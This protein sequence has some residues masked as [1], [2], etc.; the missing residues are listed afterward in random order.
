MRLK[1]G[2]IW[3]DDNGAP[4][5][6][7]GGC[8]ICHDGIWYWYGENKGADN[9]PGKKQT[10]FV[11]V[12][13][14]SSRNLLN[15]HF[16]GNV[17]CADQTDPQSPLH[18]TKV[19]ERPKVIF[20]AK[21]NNFVLWMHLDNESYSF[22]RAGVAVSDSPTGPF[23]LLAV[24]H[25]N[26]TDCRDMTVFLDIDGTAYLLHSGDWNKT[27]YISQLNNDF[28]DFTGL[29]CKTMID[30]ERE[31]PAICYHEGLYYMVTSGCTGWRPNSALYSVSPQLL[32]GARWKLIDNP[33]TGPNCRNTFGAQS[34]YVFSV[35]GRFYLLLD[36]W[37]SEAL[38]ESGYSILPVHIDGDY[39][40]IPW[41]DYFEGV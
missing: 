30:Q 7:H 22:A 33:C 37:K 36:H 31:A 35:D 24:R 32:S 10:P 11:G 40:E 8:I 29:Y 38:R 12:S 15:W 20:N 3:F 39:M 18:A 17:L 9:F 1:N 41:K 28:T 6:A 21:N 26:R 2:V 5:Q 16:E 25:A 19:C 13:C 27:M 34:A 4:I 14:Y 23:R